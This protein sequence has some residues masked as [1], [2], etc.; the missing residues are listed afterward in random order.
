VNLDPG[1]AITKLE[2][3]GISAAM[4]PGAEGEH[5]VASWALTE[6]DR[7]ARDVVHVLR[8]ATGLN[9]Q[10]KVLVAHNGGASAVTSVTP[11]GVG[12]ATP[13]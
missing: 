5:C 12:A 4:P 8:R 10:E 6:V 2:R 3:L 13:S 11:P 1:L 9:G 7:L